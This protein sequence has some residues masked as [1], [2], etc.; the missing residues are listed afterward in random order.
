MGIR[1][2]FFLFSWMISLKVGAIYPFLV[3]KVMVFKYGEMG[4]EEFILAAKFFT[5]RV[6]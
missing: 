1:K 5:K 6:R 2:N 3:Q 4:S